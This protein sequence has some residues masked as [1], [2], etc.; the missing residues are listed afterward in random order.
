MVNLYR[1]NRLPVLRAADICFAYPA[2]S[3]QHPEQKYKK[4]G[5]N[6]IEGVLLDI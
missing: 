2:F 6:A 4:E 1:I 5:G 3:A